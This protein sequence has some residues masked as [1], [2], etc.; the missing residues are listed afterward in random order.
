MLETI[1]IDSLKIRIPRYKVTY[2][3]DSFAEAYKKIYLKTG[4]IEDHVQLDKHK[5]DITDGISSRIAVFNS[6][7]GGKAEEQIV[8]Q[9]NA[10]QLKEKY[11]QGI[12]FKT[13][14]FLYQY[15]MDLKIIHVS[16]E[17]FLNAYVSDIDFC[18]DVQVSPKVMIEGNQE[19]YNHIK[20]SCFKYV[21]KPFRRS[22][23]VGIQ[24]NT[25][26]KATPSLPYV[27]IYHKT[28]ELLHK[29]ND[30]AEKH[31]KGQDY[32]N[33]GR[34][35]YTI[36]NSKHRKK[37]KIEANTF[38]ELLEIPLPQIGAAV[39]TGVLSYIERNSIERDYKDISPTDK[40]IL[41]FLHR[42]KENGDSTNDLYS[43]LNIFEI[44]Q[45]KSRMK[46]KMRQ[47]LHQVDEKKRLIPDKETEDFLKHIKLNFWRPDS[48]Q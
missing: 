9:C 28:L 13:L 15:I 4:L 40:L 26:E 29:S 18:Y 14:P 2:V 10:K 30:F 33:I 21:T 12:N 24:F 27:K 23:N 19:I 34:L 43:A 46:K 41:F 42:C 3:D 22:T 6:L 35:E 37:L 48:E 17:D 16:Y 32:N 1:K 25:R 45:E 39:F 8:I 20:P 44:A 36:K 38:K 5:V 7:Q 31:L 11:F 47:L